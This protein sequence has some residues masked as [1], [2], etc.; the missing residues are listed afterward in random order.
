MWEVWQVQQQFALAFVER[1]AL[2][3]QRGNLLAHAPH[4][5]LHCGGVFAL[6]LARTDLFADALSIGLQS[7]QLRLGCAPVAVAFKNAVDLEV[8]TA[9]A[10]TEAGLDLLGVFTND[11][12]I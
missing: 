3:V 11:A 6:G 8:G 2:F 12:D 1:G 7:L 10:G 4:L 5:R 9:P